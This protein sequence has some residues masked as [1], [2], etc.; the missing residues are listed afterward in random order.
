MRT[1]VTLEDDVFAKL[2]EEASRNRTSMKDTI[3]ELL[4]EGLRAKELN[5]SA[6]SAKFRIRPRNFGVS[7]GIPID[8]TSKL[9]NLLEGE[10]HR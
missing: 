1:T 8:S 3:N 2:Q 9:L 10:E 6:P 7:T 5:R 4:R